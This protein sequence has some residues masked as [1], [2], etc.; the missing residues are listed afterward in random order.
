M[1]L[2]DFANNNFFSQMVRV[3]TR[4][5]N[6]FDLVFVS[7]EDMVKD[8][9][10]GLGLASYDY[11]VVS[12]EVVVTAGPDTS[13]P[14]RRLNLRRVKI[15]CSLFRE[16]Q[17]LTLQPKN[18]S[19]SLGANIFRFKL[20]YSYQEFEAPQSM[21]RRGSLMRFPLQFTS[22]R[23]CI[24]RPGWTHKRLL[25][26]LRSARKYILTSCYR[27]QTC[28]HA[29]VRGREYYRIQNNI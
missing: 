24:V 19:K 11:E 26:S 8:V 1:R 9:E 21:I 6:I 23:Y 7:D 12:F 16:H 2:V 14:V 27:I 13:H 15:T 10:V 25:A 28:V 18:C 4:C 22:V 20:V 29:C 17:E 3:P 5:C